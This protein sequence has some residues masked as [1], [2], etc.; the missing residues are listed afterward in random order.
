MPNSG[1]A[2]VRRQGAVIA[3]A[4]AVALF[5]APVLKSLGLPDAL[6][7][8]TFDQLLQ[9]SMC[10]SGGGET[11][12]APDIPHSDHTNNHE[13]CIFCAVD[14]GRA[15]IDVSLLPYSFAFG[16]IE[17]SPQLILAQYHAPDIALSDGV[18]PYDISV[19]APP[20][21]LA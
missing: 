1:I 21:S 4:L 17:R 12:Q 9:H 16:D 6:S 7:L 10:L 15:N 3:A 11:Q 14:Q 20:L 5:I 2:I 8:S 18:F 19:R 13:C